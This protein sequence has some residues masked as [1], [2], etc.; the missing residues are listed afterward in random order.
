MGRLFSRER[1]APHDGDDLDVEDSNGTRACG[2]CGI[3]QN[4]LHARGRRRAS[5]SPV[6]STMGTT[7]V[8][9]LLGS[10]ALPLMLS[11]ALRASG[12]APLFSQQTT[13]GRY[14]ASTSSAPAPLTCTCASGSISAT[15]SGAFDIAK[16]SS[17]EASSPAHEARASVTRAGTRRRRRMAEHLADNRGRRE[18]LADRP[19]ASRPP[20]ARRRRPHVVAAEAR[21][22]GR[23][24]LQPERRRRRWQRDRE[25]PA[26]DR[27]G[28]DASAALIR[29]L[30]ALPRREK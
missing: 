10:G 2:L 23:R 28:D 4:P 1:A 15:L 26:P 16:R 5:Q 24:S 25:R 14:A 12:C 18:A 7:R 11:W 3:Q 20:R 19:R 30:Q 21:G 29:A 8:S 13:F 17:R 9:R 22:R 6:T 27:E